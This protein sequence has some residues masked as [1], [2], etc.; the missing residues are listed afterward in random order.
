VGHDMV[1]V[2]YDGVVDMLCGR[3]ARSCNNLGVVQKVDLTKFKGMDKNM[4]VLHLKECEF[5]FN[6][7]GKNKTRF[8]LKMF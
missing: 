1:G 7:R 6:N 5:R 4:F 8:L 3:Y 2:R